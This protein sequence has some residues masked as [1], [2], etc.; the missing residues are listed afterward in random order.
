MAQG[1]TGDEIS[2][3]EIFVSF[4]WLISFSSFEAVLHSEVN[5][6]HWSIGALVVFPENGL[7]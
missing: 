5:V 4:E 2:N 3:Y 7:K 6:L 1:K